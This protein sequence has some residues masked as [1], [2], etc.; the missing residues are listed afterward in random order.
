M[1]HGIDTDF[2]IA[3]EIVDHPFHLA[4]DHLLNDLLSDG[5][6]FVMVPQTVGEFLHVVTDARRMPSPL[7]MS[8]AIARA[9]SW[10]EA[11]EVQHV[12]P[13]SVNTLSFLALMQKHRLGRKRILDTQL[14]SILISNGIRKLITNNGTHFRSLGNLEPVSL[15][16]R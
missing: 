3:V 16:V 15:M 6:G 14:A 1:L 11:E 5:H 13:D 10:W 2:L 7:S 4:A 8:E 12:F 9:R